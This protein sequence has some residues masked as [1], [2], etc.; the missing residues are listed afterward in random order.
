M[1]HLIS[2]FWELNGE[3]DMET[4]NFDFCIDALRGS[5]TMYKQALQI[6]AQAP[7][8][9]YQAIPTRQDRTYPDRHSG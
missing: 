2:H 5:L 3:N 4:I 6:D 7:R 8:N 1:L 9:G